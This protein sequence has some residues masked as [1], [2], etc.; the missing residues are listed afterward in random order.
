MSDPP[1]A[2]PEPRL[3]TREGDLWVLDK[4]SGFAVHAVAGD[5]AP[6]LMAWARASVGAPAGLA[7]IHRLDLDASGLVLCAADSA[8]RGELGRWF[9][10]GEVH[11]Q[12]RALAW[13]RVHKKG[14]IRR[15][16]KDPR[17][18]RFL[19]A[20]TRYQ[21]LEWLGGFS[22]LALT[23]E[24]GRRHQLRRHLQGIGHSLVGD[25]RYRPKRFRA[26][27]GFPG[28]LWLHAVELVLPDG[29]SYEAPLPAELERHLEVLRE[30]QIASKDSAS[31]P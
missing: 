12:Y 27:P 2:S 26:V 3:I 11:K 30:G 14:T 29:R 4:P 18:R 13:G 9:A 6:D 24:S 22:Y 23:P 15:P 17:R 28:R 8:L 19:S 16:L 20:V 25:R 5:T 21:C 31:S 7:P 1:P 10:D